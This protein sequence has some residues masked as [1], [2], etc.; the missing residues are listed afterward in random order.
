ME[1]P[2]QPVS[3]AGASAF[4]VLK[5]ALRLCQAN[6]RE[7]LTWPSQLWLLEWTSVTVLYKDS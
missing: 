3:I 1:V 5:I 4:L 2:A 7:N 6:C